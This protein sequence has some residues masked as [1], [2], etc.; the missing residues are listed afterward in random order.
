MNNPS[1]ET[2][3]G[4]QATQR[5]KTG[6][7]DPL[8]TQALQSGP[9]AP[10]VDE[11]INTQ[12][13]PAGPPPAPATQV[14]PVG[15]PPVPPQEATMPL[16]VGSALP[17]SRAARPSRVKLWVIGVLAVVL[18]GGTLAYYLL[19]PSG[20][21]PAAIQQALKVEEDVPPVLRPYLD[22]ANQGDSG[23]MRML[24]TMYYNGLNVRQDRR[25]GIKWYRKAA[26]AGS[27]SARKDLDQ[28]GLTVDEK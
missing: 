2:D 7:P 24:G 10:P 1:D 14:L 25:E 11:A 9:P 5:L 23:A 27:V 18:L 21:A 19:Y 16:K 3:P 26:A 13:W 17:E 4:L 22:K 20:E 6:V 28:L 8:A 12:I 15:Q